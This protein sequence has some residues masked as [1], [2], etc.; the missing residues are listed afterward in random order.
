[1]FKL[2]VGQSVPRQ[3]T[4]VTT[5]ELAKT[6]ADVF[7]EMEGMPPTQEQLTLLLSHSAF[8]I[9]DGQLIS[10][11]NI[12]HIVA[13]GN[14]PYVFDEKTVEEGSGVAG[15]TIKNKSGYYILGSSHTRF[16]IYEWIGRCKAKES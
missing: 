13:V 10:N 3:K 15:Q 8:E 9:G 4:P 2:G 14:E 7:T 16:I 6:M 5:V 1:M 12:G 11:Y